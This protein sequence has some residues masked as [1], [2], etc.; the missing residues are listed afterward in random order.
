MCRLLGQCLASLA[1]S[2]PAHLLSSSS[3]RYLIAPSLPVSLEALGHKGQ[4]L[5]RFLLCLWSQRQIHRPPPP[6]NVP[7]DSGCREQRTKLGSYLFISRF[8]EMFIWKQHGKVEWFDLI[9]KSKCISSK[10]ET[11]LQL[12][13]IS[14]ADDS[15]WQCRVTV[16]ASWSRLRL[17]GHFTL[18]KGLRSLETW[19][20]GPVVGT[21]E[22]QLIKSLHRDTCARPTCVV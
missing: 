2:T 21:S 17:G 15:G 11:I 22:S 14:C 6:R 12:V 3:P 10:T 20:P 16:V 7:A 9:S 4:F 8:A 19:D 13:V 1:S 5:S 18:V